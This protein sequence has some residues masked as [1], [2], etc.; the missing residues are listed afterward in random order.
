MPAFY[1][2]VEVIKG[3]R[4]IV[5]VTKDKH[6]AMNLWGLGG[7]SKVLADNEHQVKAESVLQGLTDPL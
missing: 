1:I 2:K 4:L 7:F 6:M 3:K 5:S